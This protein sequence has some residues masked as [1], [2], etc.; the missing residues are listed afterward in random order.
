MFTTLPRVNFKDNL[1]D[2]RVS[3]ANE[4]KQKLGYNKL[5]NVISTPG[6]LLFMLRKLDIQPLVT[7][8][9]NDYKRKKE[10]VGMYSGT[11]ACLGWVTGLVLSV[12]AFVYGMSSNFNQPWSPLHYTV[13]TITALLIVITGFGT[14]AYVFDN[15]WE[16]GNRLER[17]WE[18]QEIS[19]YQG[20]IPEF[21]LSKA[22]QIKDAIPESRFYVSYLVERIDH[23]SKPKPDP[24]LYVTLGDESYYL[25]VWDEKEYEK[26]L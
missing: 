18:N 25:D 2:A 24:F 12:G 20:N 9:V 22:V 3:L 15:E 6:A 19:F 10:Y 4:A 21:A 7:S 14:C 1:E 13:N 16:H 17:E 8:R 23:R 5:A 11:K 26:T